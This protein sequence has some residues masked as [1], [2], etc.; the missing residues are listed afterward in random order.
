TR[1]DEGFEA[2]NILPCRLYWGWKD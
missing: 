2:L 1:I